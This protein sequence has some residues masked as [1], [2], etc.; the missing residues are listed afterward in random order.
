MINNK[1]KEIYKGKNIR[2]LLEDRQD[3]PRDPLSFKS[4]W[5][6]NID[7]KEPLKNKEFTEKLFGKIFVERG[8]ISRDFSGCFLLTTFTL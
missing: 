3:N 4:G 5:N 8:C 1:R 6:N 7:K 2:S